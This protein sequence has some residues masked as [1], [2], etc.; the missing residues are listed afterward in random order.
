ML[1][2]PSLP[3]NY[4]LEK[5]RQIRL[6]EQSILSI[7]TRIDE[8]YSKLMARREQEGKSSPHYSDLLY[9]Q[10]LLFLLLNASQQLQKLL[11]NIPQTQA[12]QQGMIKLV[13]AFEKTANIHNLDK[14]EFIIITTQAAK[15]S[16]DPGTSCQE[17][18]QAWQTKIQDF[19]AL[20]RHYIKETS[21]QG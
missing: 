2:L 17:R 6:A 11:H 15:K 5:R 8:E 3:K 20:K 14:G 10:I 16:L 9:G 1:G 12:A 21:N 7:E 4:E 13:S 18:L 19:L